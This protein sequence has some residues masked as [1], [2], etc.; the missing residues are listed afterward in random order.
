MQEGQEPRVARRASDAGIE[1]CFVVVGEDPVADEV[2]RVL[3]V[4]GSIADVE[5]RAALAE[6]TED[7]DTC[8]GDEK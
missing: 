7:Q 3:V 5:L 8:A 2:E 6:Y 1:R 4:L